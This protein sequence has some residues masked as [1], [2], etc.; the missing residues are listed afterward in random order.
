MKK[1]RTLP[2]IT[3]GRILAELA[4]EGFTLTRVTFYRLERRLG[5]P[6]GKRTHGKIQWRVYTR[7]Q[8]NAVKA[9]IKKE[10]NFS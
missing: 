9:A 4:E 8:A 1:M 10:Y 7:E 2:Y 5:F 3:V 6:A